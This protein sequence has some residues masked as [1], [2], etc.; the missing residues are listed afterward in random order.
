MLETREKYQLRKH[1]KF[2]LNP[3]AQTKFFGVLLSHGTNAHSWNHI[4]NTPGLKPD[5]ITLWKRDIVQFNYESESDL[6]SAPHG[7][8]ILTCS[9]INFWRQDETKNHLTGCLK[10]NFSSFTSFILHDISVGMT[11]FRG[12]E[13]SLK[14]ERA[15]TLTDAWILVHFTI[16]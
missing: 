14:R 10:T 15:I 13:H 4:T 8:N 9:S 16:A 2:A 6:Y 5:S 1:E 7:K 11:P 3:C 12:E